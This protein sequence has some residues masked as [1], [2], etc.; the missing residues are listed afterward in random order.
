V[1]WDG[2]DW[3][4]QQKHRGHRTPFYCLKHYEILDNGTVVFAL[5]T[6]EQLSLSEEQYVLLDVAL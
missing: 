3:L 6:G 1:P 5:K 4:R 2:L